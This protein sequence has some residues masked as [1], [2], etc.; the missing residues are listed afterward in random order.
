M[1]RRLSFDKSANQLVPCTFLSTINNHRTQM[2][3][4]NHRRCKTPPNNDPPDLGK[5][6]FHRPNI[7]CWNNYNPPNLFFKESS[8]S[9]PGPSQAF[10]NLTNLLI[11]SQMYR[12]C[13]HP[14][15]SSDSVILPNFARFRNCETELYRKLKSQREDCDNSDIHCLK[16]LVAYRRKQ[17]LSTT[18]RSLL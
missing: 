1:S 16:S 14:C 3:S 2:C 8:S 12:F 15:V 5:L 11:I 7:R 6:V 4:N 10:H 17:F 13:H 9:K 18:S